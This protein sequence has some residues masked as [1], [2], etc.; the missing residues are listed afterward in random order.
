MTAKSDPGQS[1]PARVR[2]ARIE[3]HEQRLARIKSEVAPRACAGRGL[4]PLHTV[5]PRNRTESPRARARGAD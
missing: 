3:T 5:T 1:R 4:K 2:G